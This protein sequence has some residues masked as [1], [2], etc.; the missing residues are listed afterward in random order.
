LFKPKLTYLFLG[1]LLFTLQLQAKQDSALIETKWD[2][3]RVYNYMMKEADSDT[4]ARLLT[5]QFAK[6]GGNC[7]A[8]Y[9]PFGSYYYKLEMP[10]KDPTTGQ[11]S[12]DDETFPIQGRESL[13]RT[14]K[15]SEYSK[16]AIYEKPNFAEIISARKEAKSAMVSFFK[17][18]LAKQGSWPCGSPNLGSKK[19][20]LGNLRENVEYFKDPETEEIVCFAKGLEADTIRDP[21]SCAFIEAKTEL[22]NQVCNFLFKIAR[23]S[24]GA[25][26]SEQA[27]AS[28]SNGGANKGTSFGGLATLTPELI[29]QRKLGKALLENPD[30]ELD[31]RTAETPHLDEYLP[32]SVHDLLKR[33]KLTDTSSFENFDPA[34][35]L[36]LVGLNETVRLAKS[37]TEFLQPS[38][39]LDAIVTKLKTHVDVVIQANNT[40]TTVEFP[41]FAIPKAKTFQ[42]EFSARLTRVTD[43]YGPLK[44]NQGCGGNV[45]PLPRWKF[46]PKF[47]TILTKPTIQQEWYK[48]DSL[49]DFSTMNSIRNGVI[50]DSLISNPILSRQ[51]L[52]KT[53]PDYKTSLDA[54]GITKFGVTGPTVNGLGAINTGAVG[55]AMGGAVGGAV[56][57]AA[58]GAL[59]N[60]F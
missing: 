22:P 20:S 46:N 4:V 60:G 52:V 30:L 42:T 24:D 11:T 55:G 29:K 1:S 3:A 34:L 15:F 16:I 39:E 8:S 58:A 7:K 23:S 10:I 47:E 37:N 9:N 43:L 51:D 27:P 48:L 49:V 19:L 31:S 18:Q 56:G 41:V 44:F 26:L 45:R 17:T 13:S 53:V 54:A 59:K 57:G 32:R 40:S 33:I 21:S 35:Q 6:L 28:N 2:E 14:V 36:Q 12:V 5:T 25:T 38:S 50:G